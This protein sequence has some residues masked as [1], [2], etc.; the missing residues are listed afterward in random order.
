MNSYRELHEDVFSAD[1]KPALEALEAM[2]ALGTDDPDEPERVSMKDIELV[3][4]VFQVR[5]LDFDEHHVS[6]LLSLLKQGRDLDPVVVWR[7]GRH[8][9]LVDGHHR[10][11]AYERY[12]LHLKRRVE[13][14]VTW[15]GGS[16]EQAMEA[17]AEANVQL[18][19]PMTPTQRNNFA[20]KLVKAGRFSRPKTAELSGVS[21][22]HVG[23]MR[24]V[25]QLLGDKADG[26]E[27]WYRAQQLAEKGQIELDHDELEAKRE[28]QVEAWAHLMSKAFTNK[29]STNP[30][31]A[32]RVLDRYF[33][34]NA[35]EVFKEW[36]LVSDTVT[37]DDVK[38]M[39]IEMPF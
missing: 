22:R 17:A 35:P 10:K 19:L 24:K 6:G 20:W 38:E 39:L 28:A 11:A 13:I 8:V 23:N 7:C 31:M 3:P 18:K 27:T 29:L 2:T 32:A 26:C 25:K 14:P 9:L 1:L 16:A 15:F 34:R 37:H 4:H 5:G 12:Q 36:L 33:G 21:E 30:T